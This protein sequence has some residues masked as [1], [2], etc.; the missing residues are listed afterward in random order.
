MV[1]LHQTSEI[2]FEIS[3][4]G[5]KKNMGEILDQKTVQALILCFK[6]G[7]APTRSEAVE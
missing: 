3:E 7:H 2:L 1:N 4:K 5:D 6:I